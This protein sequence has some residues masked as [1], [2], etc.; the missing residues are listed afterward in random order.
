MQ[1]NQ[2]VLERMV[3]H[4]ATTSIAETL[5]RLVAADA[6]TDHFLPQSRLHWLP[7]TPTLDGLLDM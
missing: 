5:V 7:A 3:R 2:G 6:A 1:G 4:L